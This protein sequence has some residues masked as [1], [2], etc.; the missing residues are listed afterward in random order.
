MNKGV[1]SSVLFNSFN[2]ASLFFH[3]V[4]SFLTFHCTFFVLSSYNLQKK[5]HS[6][7]ELDGDA[8]EFI[9]VSLIWFHELINELNT[10]IHSLFY[11]FSNTKPSF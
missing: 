1:F 6:L 3:E 4:L 7:D 11:Y 5:F 10:S 2:M 9:A 8:I